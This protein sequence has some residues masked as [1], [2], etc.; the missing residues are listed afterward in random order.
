MK[1]IFEE[2]WRASKASGGDL[3]LGR[4]QVNGYE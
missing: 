1:R 2:S 3:L 4:G